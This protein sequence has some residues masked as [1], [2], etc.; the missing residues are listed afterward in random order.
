MDGGINANDNFDVEAATGKITS[1]DG[2]Y[3]QKSSSLKGVVVS[4]DG[5][6]GLTV[7]SGAESKLNG[8]I[9]VMNGADTKFSVDVD[10]AVSA[11]G[12]ASLDGGVLQ[13]LINFLLTL[14]VKSEQHP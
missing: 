11:A 5:A 4:A 9:K 6:Q 14:M 12:L 8:G 7:D 1:S 2:I 10:G 13:Y 3:T